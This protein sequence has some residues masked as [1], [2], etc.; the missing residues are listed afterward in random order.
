MISVS[1]SWRPHRQDREPRGQTLQKS[2]VSFPISSL[3]M[4]QKERENNQRQQEKREI[5]ICDSFYLL[6]TQ[7]VMRYTCDALL[8]VRR[9]KL[10]IAFLARERNEPAK[11]AGKKQKTKKQ[12]SKKANKPFNKTKTSNHY[13]DQTQ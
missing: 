10:H 5:R 4:S 13:S 12:T 2:A 11:A 7:L 1:G 9:Y 3:K 6:L 8:C